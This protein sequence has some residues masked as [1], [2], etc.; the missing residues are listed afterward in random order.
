[1][2][3]DNQIVA[4]RPNT[5]F[6]QCFTT[7]SEVRNQ[8]PKAD[9]GD[10]ATNTGATGVK[11]AFGTTYRDSPGTLRD[12]HPTLGKAVAGPRFRVVGDRSRHWIGS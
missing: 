9:A 6:A 7:A 12:D 5:A 4:V 10:E 8:H 2:A 3:K 1:M 11:R